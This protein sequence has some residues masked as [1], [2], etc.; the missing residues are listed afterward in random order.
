MKILIAKTDGEINKCFAVLSQLRTNLT[1]E[2]FFDNVKKQKKF[3][4]RLA[5]AEDN[6]KV[7][8]VAGFRISESLAWGKF[9]YIDDLITDSNSRSKGYGNKLMD[10]LID[11]AK[12]EKCDELHLDSGVQRY[13][14]HRFYL[15]KRMD[16]T[17]HHFTLRL[18]DS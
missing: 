14:A 17:A 6:G 10:W 3:G 15:H 5:F 18:K 2:K 13:G 9:M 7:V 1:I 12:N 4:Y 8:C 16:I 11:Y